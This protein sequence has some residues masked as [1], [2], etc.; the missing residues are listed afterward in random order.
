ME[1]EEGPFVSNRAEEEVEEANGLMVVVNDLKIF[2]VEVKEEEFKDLV[3][4]VWILVSLAGLV[5]EEEIDLEEEEEED[6]DFQAF[7]PKRLQ[8][9]FFTCFVQ[10]PNSLAGST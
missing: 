10:A 8:A 2:F 6:F 3:V 5:V 7:F 1:D 9:N 4:V